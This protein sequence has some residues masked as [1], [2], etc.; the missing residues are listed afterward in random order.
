MKTIQERILIAGFMLALLSVLA[1]PDAWAARKKPQPGDTKKP[2][3]YYD[4]QI[5]QGNKTI[6]LKQGDLNFR[7]ALLY[8]NAKAGLYGIPK[9]PDLKVDIKPFELFVFDP[10]TAG[11]GIRLSRLGFVQ[12][13]PASSFDLRPNKVDPVIFDKIYQI[14]YDASIPIN[15]WCVDKDI[16]LEITPVANKPGWFRVVPLQT[17]AEGPYAVNFGCMD[18]P[19]V[20]TGE[21]YFYPFNVAKLPEP[22]PPPVC[23]PRVRK[24]PAREVAECVPTPKPPQAAPRPAPVSVP[25]PGKNLNAQF[26]YIAVPTSDLKMRREYQVTNTNDFPWHNV[27]ISV[28]MR[29][30]MFPETVLGPVTLYKDVVLPAHTVNPVPDKTFMHYATLD[31]EGCKL[32][33]KVSSKEGVI[34]KA[35][36]NVSTGASG[37]ANLVETTWDLKDE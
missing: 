12:T 30:G 3:K 24:A 21:Q 35:W 2:S 19:K 1:C 11:A 17:L 4:P 22:P 23:K 16:T 31:D 32:Y 18:G 5:Q 26:A 36:K 27:N 13:A 37:E 10:E 8:G 34:K 7:T 20:Y 25:A 29:D 28:F 6:P 15:L 33:L 14:S 9:L